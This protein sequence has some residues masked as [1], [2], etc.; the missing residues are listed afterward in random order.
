[1]KLYLVRSPSPP[2]LWSITLRVRVDRTMLLCI[3]K[4]PFSE[5]LVV[6][7]VKLNPP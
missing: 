6:N 1:M 5:K 3:L 7:L 2:T 4:P